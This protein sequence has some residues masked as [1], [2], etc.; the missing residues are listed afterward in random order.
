MSID[1]EAI[2]DRRRLRRK[3]SFWRVLGISPASSLP[4]LRWAGRCRGPGGYGAIQNQI[5]RISV[6]GV[7][8]GNQRLADLMQRVGDRARSQA[9]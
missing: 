3:L 7:I 2:A 4:W 1:A 5:A 6:D 9:S 8:T